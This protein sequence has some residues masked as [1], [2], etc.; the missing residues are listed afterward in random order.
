MAGHWPL[1]ALTVA[2]SGAG[3][4]AAAAGGL[5]GTPSAP[6]GTF[7]RSL[8][9]ADGGSDADRMRNMTNNLSKVFMGAPLVAR[10]LAVNGLAVKVNLFPVGARFGWSG[11]GLLIKITP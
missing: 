6:P 5:L 11:L 1:T 9:W 7:L 4:A 3:V 10:R 8:A 2:G